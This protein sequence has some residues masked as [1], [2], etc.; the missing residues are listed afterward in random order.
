MK[1]TPKG[2]KNAN[3]SG[4]KT[5]RFIELAEHTMNDVTNRMKKTVEQR[6]ILAKKDAKLFRD[7]KNTVTMN[8]LNNFERHGSSTLDRIEVSTGR[9]ETAFAAERNKF[10][11]TTR[12]TPVHS[13]A[14]SRI[15]AMN[16]LFDAFKNNRAS[17]K[18]V[19]NFVIVI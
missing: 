14:A 1:T 6:A 12:R 4:S 5:L 10:E 18:G 8:A 7:G 16:H 3:K 13:S 11:R 9:T 17:F 19:F 2:M 15:S